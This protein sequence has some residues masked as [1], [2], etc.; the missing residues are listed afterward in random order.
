METLRSLIRDNA[1]LQACTHA[2]LEL[3]VGWA[4]GAGGYLYLYDTQQDRLDTA[5]AGPH[6]APPPPELARRVLAALHATRD[7]EHEQTSALCAADL[8]QVSTAQRDRV[9][10]DDATYRVL[11]LTTIED[12]D[13]RLVGAVAVRHGT[14]PITPPNS[15]LLD[16]VARA[17][18]DAQDHALAVAQPSIPN[19][20][21]R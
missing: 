16:A 17:L 5:V 2:A 10:L 8:A 14:D 9:V 1:D 13:L 20:T 7:A 18:L 21:Q 19:L 6:E 4:H 12:L 15:R 11:V 3:V